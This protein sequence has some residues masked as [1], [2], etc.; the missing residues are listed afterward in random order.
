MTVAA[1]AE[2]LGLQAV[3]AVADQEIVGAIATDLISDVLAH[4]EPGMVWLTIQTHRNVA[5]VASTQELAAV[6]V[7]GDRPVSRELLAL[8]EQQAVTI[9]VSEDDTYGTSGRLY[10]L[11]VH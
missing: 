3:T 6:I 4:G 2:A 7:T 10:E 9:F 1:M 5:A 11:G 8:A